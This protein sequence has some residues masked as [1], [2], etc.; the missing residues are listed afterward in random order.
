MY[1][2]SSCRLW[3]SSS[4]TWPSS[5]SP[6]GPCCSTNRPRYTQT[7]GHVSTVFLLT[8]HKKNWGM[9]A[10]QRT[11]TENSTQIFPQPQ[12]QFSPSC[13]CERFIYYCVRSAYSAAGKYVDRSWYYKNDP[14]NI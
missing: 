10:L 6:S 11:N 8:G 9:S 3:W 4:A 12:S 14:G 7:T 13:V 2:A 5:S 1:L